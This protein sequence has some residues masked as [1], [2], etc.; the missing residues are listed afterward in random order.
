MLQCLIEVFEGEYHAHQ[1]ERYRNQPGKHGSMNTAFK[2]LLVS[3][4][5]T[6]VGDEFMLTAAGVDV[7]DAAV[8]SAHVMVREG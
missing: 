2:S 6:Q 8:N 3:G 7:V 5:I 4:L 1:S